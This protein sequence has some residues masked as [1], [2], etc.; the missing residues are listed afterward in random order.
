MEAGV[1]DFTRGVDMDA[2]AAGECGCAD[3]MLGQ[4]ERQ[5]ADNAEPPE[6]D[7]SVEA[8]PVEESDWE[9]WPVTVSGSWG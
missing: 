8:F 5:T 9:D 1:S 6:A 4:D 7:E 2:N 3:R